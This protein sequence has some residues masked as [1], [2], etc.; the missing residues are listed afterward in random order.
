MIYTKMTETAMQIAYA[1]HAGQTDKVGVPYVF[2]P[3]HVAEQMK[4]EAT[5]TA[6]LLHDVVE[7]SEY[8]LDDLRAAGISSEVI[9]A[10]DLLT[11]KSGVDYMEY[12]KEIKQNPI[13][14]A[15]KIGD[16][17]HNS[18]TTRGCIDPPLLEKIKTKYAAALQYLSEE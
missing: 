17:V 12:I 18:D 7:D 15:V 1:A 13:A 14:R 3:Y 6:A 11:K 16:L 4:T 9:R 10:V 2:H 8:T 5:V